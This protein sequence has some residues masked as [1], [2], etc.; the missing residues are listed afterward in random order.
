MN[1]PDS[2]DSPE[3]SSQRRLEF[4]RNP[5]SR[6]ANVKLESKPLVEAVRAADLEMVRAALGQLHSNQLALDQAL[7]HA[8]WHGTEA[9]WPARKAVADF[10]IGSGANPN[11]QYGGDYGPIAVGTVEFLQPD[12]LQYLIDAGANVSYRLDK[13]KF[14]GLCPIDHALGSRIRGCNERKHRVIE[15]LLAH[16]AHIPPEVAPPILTIHR[17]DARRLG[18]HIDAE[19]S[20]LWRKFPDMPYG[21]MSLRGGSLLHCAVEFGEIECA[22]ELLTLMADINM[23][24]EVI[25]GIGGQTPIFHAIGELVAGDSAMLKYLCQRTGLR[26]D[27]SMAATWRIHGEPQGNPTTALEFVRNVATG[28]PGLQLDKELE[29]L[30]ELD[31]SSHLERAILKNDVV[32][33]ERL[34]DGRPR[35]LKSSLWIDVI[36]KAGSLELAR[37]L[38]TRGLDPDRCNFPRKPLHLAVL[39]CLPDIVELLLACGADVNLRTTRKETAL[40]LLDTSEPRP[41]GD[42]DSARIR[43]ILLNAGAKDNLHTLIRAGDVEA[44]R[45]LLEADPFL[46]RSDAEPGGPLFVAADCCRVEVVKLLLAHGAE[47]DRR[48]NEGNTPLWFA[49]KSGV[50]SA[51]DRIAV[52]TILL[53]A[54][55]D[56]HWRGEEGATVLHAA[57]SRGPAEVVQFLLVRGATAWVAD[58]RNLTPRDWAARASSAWDKE[59]TLRLFS[60]VRILDPLFRAAVDAMDGGDIDGLRE[61]LRSHPK[62]ISRRAEEDG[63]FGG[64]NFRRPALLHFVANYPRRREAMPPRTLEIAEVLLDAGAEIDA[65]TEE[66]AGATALELVAMSDSA[67]EAG[68]QAPLIELLVR[69]GADS[70]RGLDAAVLYGESPAIGYLR[71][72]GAQHTLVS[73]AAFG[74]I[75]PLRVF[76]QAEP[77]RPALMNAALAAARHGDLNVLKALLKRLRISERMTTHPASPTLLHVAARYDQMHIV[78]WLLSKGADLLVRDLRDHGTPA[79]WA[80]AGKHTMIATLLSEEEEKA[81]WARPYE[82]FKQVEREM[83]PGL[84]EKY[85]LRC[86][87]NSTWGHTSLG[88]RKSD[89]SDASSH[90]IS[91][92]VSVRLRDPAEGRLCYHFDTCRMDRLWDFDIQRE[93]FASAFRRELLRRRLVFP[94]LATDLRPE[95]LMEGWVP[96]NFETLRKDT[97]AFLDRFVKIYWI[98][99][100]LLEERRLT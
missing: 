62:L 90:W 95:R 65:V 39:H 63:W 88:L 60:E 57:A 72:A 75:E 27:L 35:L 12:A 13:E 1:T 58:D 25:E 98:F 26:I 16:D 84:E 7:A 22:K 86:G 99:A 18:A 15:I 93:E 80:R 70:A 5:T 77:S 94:N 100:R 76:L 8:L 38:L 2:G 61:L 89:W 79:R 44:V 42:P 32:A 68:L 53:D 47:P 73:S 20:L 11:G 29:M 66:A 4:L 54:G 52:M 34:L 6:A 41:L 55:A 10:L 91:I 19:V 33:V 83:A 64:P 36:S 17:G 96:L 21:N 56:L 69:R 37:L 85:D 45:G 14:G 97:L 59:A 31:E 50:S 67:R 82:V 74:K 43:K 24:S 48:N 71:R 87:A 9:N 28:S 30:T 46:V 3:P 81:K 51:A 49:A 40:D 23:P 78:Y 92:A